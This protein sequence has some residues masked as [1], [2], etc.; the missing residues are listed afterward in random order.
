[1]VADAAAGTAAASPP[2]NP[3][4]EGTR[5]WWRVARIKNKFSENWRAGAGVGGYRDLTVCL[6]FEGKR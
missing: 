5:S 4:G 1:M 3:L 6:V 2:T